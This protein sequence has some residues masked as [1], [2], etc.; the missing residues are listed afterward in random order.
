M[1]LQYYFEPMRLEFY[2]EMI[3]DLDAKVTKMTS[4]WTLEVLYD[5]MYDNMLETEVFY[6]SFTAD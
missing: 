1:A 4:P 5:N 2:D 6:S 3:P